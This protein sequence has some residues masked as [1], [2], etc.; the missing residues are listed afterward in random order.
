MPLAPR[1]PWS[2][3]ESDLSVADRRPGAGLGVTLHRVNVPDFIARQFYVAGS[4]RNTTDGF[5]LEA[6]NPMGSGTLVGVG[7]L[8]VDG[9]DID[10]ASVSAQRPGE[11]P[12][13]A[14]DVNATNPIRVS[15]GD[16]V[17]LRV[18][19]EQLAPGR[20]ELEVTLYEVNLG[21]LAFKINDDL[22]E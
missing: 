3:R 17:V 6:Q 12:V 19:G 15:V 20:H 5:E 16:R 2:A 18:D 21:R 9:R 8:R 7:R 10:P 13:R 14:N 4:L 22:A 11:E 1:R